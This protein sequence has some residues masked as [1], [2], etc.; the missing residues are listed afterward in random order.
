MRRKLLFQ[1]ADFY[2]A[3]KLIFEER[4]LPLCYRATWMHGLGPV[5]KKQYSK[6]ILI[7]YNEIYLPVHLV[8]NEET[9]EFLELEEVESVAVG[10]PF[11]YTNNFQKKKRGIDGCK[12][13]YM[14]TH[15]VGKNNQ[16]SHHKTWKKIIKKY[17][18]DAICLTGLD[19]NDVVKTSANLGDVKIILGATPD[20][21]SSLE[22]MASLFSSTK[23]V[24]TDNIGSHL[25]YAASSGVKVRVI[26]EI[27][28]N[29]DLDA[30]TPII[31][32]VA[33]KYRQD[34]EKYF[35]DPKKSLDNDLSSIWLTGNDK[36]IKEYA[37]YSLGIHCKKST[38]EMKRLLKPT[39]SIEQTKILFYLI[40]NKIYNKL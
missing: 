7:H 22:R 8:N 34:Y 9:K 1:E 26:N 38:E 6:N 32:T 29:F 13:L 27:S 36:E 10:V 17:K 39:N 16:L 28:D 40:F 35:S 2:G 11:V 5:S 20:D 30:R 31:K 3:S 37:D 4:E 25:F 33:K 12:R 23:E 19:Y 24:I 18:C 15:S 14:P 21:S